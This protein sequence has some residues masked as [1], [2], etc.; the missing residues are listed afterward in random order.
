M[1]CGGGGVG[2]LDGCA[3]LRWLASGGLRCGVVKT[4][5]K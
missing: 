3:G 4:A 1:G 5:W 2:V